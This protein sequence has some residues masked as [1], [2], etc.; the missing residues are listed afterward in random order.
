MKLFN[1]AFRVFYFLFSSLIISGP[2]L[3]NGYP[4]MYFDSSNYIYQSISLIATSTNPI[5]YPLFIRAFSWQ[6]SLWPVIF[7]Q[8]LILS[9]L[10]YFVIKSILQSKNTIKYH[11][12]I[13][14]L[15]SFFSSMSWVSSTIMAD[16]FTP[17]SILS[18][19]L[20]LSNKSK[21]GIKIFAFI[22]LGFACLAHFSNP[23]IIIA[24]IILV[25]ALEYF[26]YRNPI[27]EKLKIGG[28]LLI[29]VIASMFFSKNY[30]ALFTD[31]GNPKSIR[32][33]LLM[34]RM[35]E[36]GILEEYLDEHC[37]DNRYS[38][39]NYKDKLPKIA[40]GFVW[41]KNSVFS[42]TGSWNYSKE[43]Y[44]EIL[45]DIFTD[46]AYLSLFAYKGVISTFKQLFTFRVDNIVLNNKSSVN[47]II[48]RKFKHEENK[49]HNSLQHYTGKLDL[50]HFNSYFYF[51]YAFSLIIIIIFL[52]SKEL[53]R[54]K[55]TR[56]FILIIIGG[57]FINAAVT[58][59]FSNVVPRYQA[60]VN[61][62]LILAAS[63][64]VIKYF[65]RILKNVQDKVKK[66]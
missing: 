20:L 63:L 5:G 62:L 51:F 39:C 19:Y 46:P 15:L 18:L 35:A 65:Y 6:F 16:I 7:A 25:Q 34:A 48:H 2:A 11:I 3:Y 57:I 58:G 55:E 23:V 31:K 49:F 64:I 9:V 21:T 29:L 41:S 36:S 12:A 13:I 32:H 24:I 27:K 61:W 30:N 33:V 50:K 44:D 1:K 4:I 17:I 14:T 42:L 22:S 26:I 40:S 8:G 43:E 38:L 56:V 53:K 60:R 28:V 52:S 45:Y 47:E 66:V 59:T 37:D 54:D 10:I